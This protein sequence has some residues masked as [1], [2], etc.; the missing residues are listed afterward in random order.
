M[1]LNIDSDELTGVFVALSHPDRRAIIEKLASGAEATVS[2]LA[3]DFDVSFNQ[4][5][6]HLKTLER[7]GLLKRRKQGREH[8]CQLDMRPLLHARTWM[9]A[10]ERFWTESIE[11]LSD[12]LDSNR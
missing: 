12:Y 6:K 10:Y 7:A 11:A 5:S 8:H 1:R 9:E 4:V 3:A 2:D